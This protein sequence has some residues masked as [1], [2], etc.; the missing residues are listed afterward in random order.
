MDDETEQEQFARIM[1]DELTEIWI[2]RFPRIDER[3]LRTR[4]LV[5][6]M[7]IMGFGAERK[8]G[9]SHD[10]LDDAE[11]IAAALVEHIHVLKRIKEGTVTGELSDVID[12]FMRGIGKA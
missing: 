5:S 8:G 1:G 7:S 6:L 11:V 4:L 2:K 12:T 3:G 9:V 10:E